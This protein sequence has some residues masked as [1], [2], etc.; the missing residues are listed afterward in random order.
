MM[1][2]P[3]QRTII[4]MTMVMIITSMTIKNTQMEVQ[5]IM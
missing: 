1:P 4:I 3:T 2:I 5:N